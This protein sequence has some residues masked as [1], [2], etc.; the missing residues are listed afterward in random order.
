MPKSKNAQRNASHTLASQPKVQASVAGFGLR[1]PHI[2]DVIL[3]KPNAGFLEVHS[4]NYFAKGGKSLQDLH[5]IAEIYPLSFHGVALSLGSVS[6]PNKNHL[7]HLKKLIDTFNP[8]LVSEH[9]AWSITDGVYLNDLLPLPYTQEALDV[10]CRNI[11]MTQQALGRQILIENPSAYLSYNLPNMMSEAEFIHKAVEK[12]SC[13]VLLD[14]NNAFISSQNITKHQ[15]TS[16]NPLEFMPFDAVQEIHLAGHH[17]QKTEGGTLLI[18]THATQVC[19]EVWQLYQYVIKHTGS[20]PTLIEW[21]DDIPELSVL[22]KE[23]EKAT[24]ILQS[25]QHEGISHVA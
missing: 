11:D 7:A 17:L 13:G 21:D 14:V 10:L 8:A 6:K 16:K 9:I 18:D 19:D 25:I 20:I 3:T 1:S 15:N 24:E 5:K 23:A 4:E 2:E 22:L 12:T